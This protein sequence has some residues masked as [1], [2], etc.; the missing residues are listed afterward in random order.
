MK[1]CSVSGPAGKCMGSQPRVAE[2]LQCATSPLLALRGL[3]KRFGKVQ[4]LHG[5]DLTVAQGEVVCVI[6]PSG[7]GKSTLLRAINFLVE[8]D[9]GEI[10]LEGRHVGR[11][12]RYGRLARDSEA[13]INY[14]RS[15]I[16]MV[17]QT[18]NLWPHMTVL[19]NIARSPIVVSGLR[20]TE[21]ETAALAHI[22]RMGLT[23]KRDAYP[24][25]LSGGQ[26]QRVAIARA[27][28]MNPVLLLFDEPTSALDPEL[29][30]EVLTVMRQLAAEGRT[31]IVVTHE[32]GFAAHAANRIV[33]MD[34]G[35]IVESGPP[36]TL[37][38]NPRS[39]RLR[40]F[41]SMILSPSTMLGV[42]VQLDALRPPGPS[43]PEY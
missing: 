6:G 41:L 12:P 14:L 27:L 24:A 30:G 25:E 17:F 28:A 33:F 32:L 11:V 29:I 16:G 20:R 19:E 15:R 23:D 37:L 4:A 13:N 43:R 40:E 35:Q 10:V 1:S 34:H 31:M 18:F 8:P 2:S 42:S 3:A 26:Q 39:L 36:A 7:C 22:N 21:A 5:V 38:R 9:E